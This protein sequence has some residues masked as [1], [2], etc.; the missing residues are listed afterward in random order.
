MS[1]HDTQTTA[2]T[3]TFGVLMFPGFQ[4]LD[5]VGPI[6]YLHSHS[7]EV[8]EALKFPPQLVQKAFITKWHY[9]SS[10]GTLD[11]V[12]ATSG[13]PQNPTTTFATCPKL[14][15]LLLPGP[16]PDLVLS[17]ECINFIKTRYP[18]LEGIFTVC[19]GSMML[20]QTGLLDGVR[21]CSNKFM[22]K[23][24]AEQGWLN[25]KVKWVGDRRFIV[26][27]K[28]WTAGGVTA[29]IDL[30]A[31]FVRVKGD[32]EIAKM[33]A[34]GSEYAPNPSQPDQFARL[35]EGVKLD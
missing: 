18:D 32:P 4:W 19:T 22:L 33:V 28:F 7:R 6:D 21:A 23:I 17:D 29:G 25:R 11:P 8:L 20:A 5:A 15:Y 35:L 12:Q 34:D 3:Y 26:E 30:A 24:G 27:G 13:P 9:L 14:D 31:E 2:R 10:T 1:S 16:M